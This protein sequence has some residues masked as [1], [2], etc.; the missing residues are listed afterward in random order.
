MCNRIA[1][2]MAPMPQMFKD[3]YKDGF[4]LG[5]KTYGNKNSSGS[6]S[7]NQALIDA[8]HRKCMSNAVQ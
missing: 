8:H 2:P 7:G 6:S 5:Y 3:G 4:S 1:I